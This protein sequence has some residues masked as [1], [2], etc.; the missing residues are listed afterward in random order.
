MNLGICLT[1]CGVFSFLVATMAIGVMMGRRP[2]SGSCGGDGRVNG[3][4]G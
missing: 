3:G 4:N 2:L 1:V